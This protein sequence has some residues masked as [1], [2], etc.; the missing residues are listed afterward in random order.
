MK[1]KQPEAALQKAVAEYLAVQLKGRAMWRM[2]ENK[3]R[4]PIAGA[5]QKKRGV[6]AGTPD[7]LLWW[8]KSD[9]RYFA[10][11]ELKSKRGTQSDCQRDFEAEFTDWHGWYFVCRSV[12]EV[13]AALR[14][15]GLI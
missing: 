15:C 6:Q 3:P 11:I 9:R 10:A 8:S 1:R 7:I 5:N 13:K 2:I 4:N 12:D 14:D